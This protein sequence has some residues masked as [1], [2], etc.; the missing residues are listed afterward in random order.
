[1]YY[2]HCKSG[3]EKVGDICLGSISSVQVTRLG[4]AVSAMLWKM[5]VTQT[6]FKL[7]I[8]LLGIAKWHGIIT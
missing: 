4:R 1:M 3:M 8:L 7:N 5:K 6:G 2:V